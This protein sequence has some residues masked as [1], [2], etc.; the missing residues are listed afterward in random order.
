MGDGILKHSSAV[1][2][3]G[4][5][6]PLAT[7]WE[8]VLW[9]LGRRRRYQV[10]GRSLHPDLRNGESVL[11]KPLMM[12]APLLVGDIVVARHP[13]QAGLLLVKRVEKCEAGRVTLS[14]NQPDSTDSR[15]FG[16]LPRSD[17]LAKAVATIPKRAL[18][19]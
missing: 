2:S 15:Q 14:G 18:L 7:A 19:R 1:L 8:L 12:A 16:S 13:Y 10:A 9:R 11:A 3:S 6:I 17:I 5:L 4:R